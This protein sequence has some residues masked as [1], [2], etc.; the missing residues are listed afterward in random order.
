M[1]AKKSIFAATVTPKLE[2]FSDFLMFLPQTEARMMIIVDIEWLWRCCQMILSGS[3]LI[4]ENS[5]KL[6]TAHCVCTAQYTLF[7]LH[8]IHTALH[9]AQ[10]TLFTLHCFTKTQPALHY[11]GSN[12]HCSTAQCAFFYVPNQHSAQ[13]KGLSDTC[14]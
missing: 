13:S 2:A 5:I 12:V 4:L 7:T 9:I 8:T 1:I 10:Y 3:E 14:Y 11:M 6:N